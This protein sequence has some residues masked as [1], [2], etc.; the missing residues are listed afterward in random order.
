MYVHCTIDIL[1][2]SFLS[3]W[4]SSNIYASIIGILIYK[5]TVSL[6]NCVSIRKDL[7][8]HLTDILLLKA[9]YRFCKGYLTPQQNILKLNM[10]YPSVLKLSLETSLKVHPLAHITK[11]FT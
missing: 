10:G 8:N 7:S 9:C 5:L 4:L 11:V 3:S 2:H 6:Y 1:Y